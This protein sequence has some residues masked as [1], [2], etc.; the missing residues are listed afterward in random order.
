VGGI[1]NSMQKDEQAVRTFNKMAL[2][3][4]ATKGTM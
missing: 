4:M 3:A 2:A 1:K